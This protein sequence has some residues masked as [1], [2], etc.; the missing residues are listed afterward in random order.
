M[1]NS[2]MAHQEPVTRGSTDRIPHK[3]RPDQ[4][5]LRHDP[6]AEGIGDTSAPS[7]RDLLPLNHAAHCHGAM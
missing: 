1:V 5:P 3:D 2:E 4:A 7:S 6:K